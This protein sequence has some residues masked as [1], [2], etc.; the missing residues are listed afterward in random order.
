MATGILSVAAAQ[1]GAAVLSDVFFAVACAEGVILAA[2]AV[3][4]G[5][6]DCGPFENFAVV[7][8]LDVLAMRAALSAPIASA[9]LS[10]TAAVAFAVCCRGLAS[11]RRRLE[12]GGVALL[13]VVAAESLAGVAGRLELHWRSRALLLVGVVLWSA[14]LALYA[15]LVLVLA[16]ALWPAQD[17]RRVTPDWWIVMGALSIVTVS[18]YWVFTSFDRSLASPLLEATWIAAGAWIPLLLV[19]EVRRARAVQPFWRYRPAAWATVFP[20]GMYASAS[21]SVGRLTGID[22]L[23]VA[24]E[25]ILGLGVAA[26]LLASIDSTRCAL[27]QLGFVGDGSGNLAR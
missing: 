16:P 1:V 15:T 4:T 20:I 11:R 5:L 14:G 18:G 13:V 23:R 17:P 8:A 10:A 3:Y 6:D 9:V 2:G 21:F 26:W 27:R 24:S 19:A 12:I 25:V 22:G 7:A